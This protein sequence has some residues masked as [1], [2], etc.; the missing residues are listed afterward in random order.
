MTRRKQ[1]DSLSKRFPTISALVGSIGNS[2]SQHPSI[3]GGTAA[4]VVAFGFVSINALMYQ[5]GKHPAPLYNTRAAQ[6]D[7]TSVASKE[8]PLPESRVTT[9]KIEHSDPQSTASIPRKNPLEAINRTVLQLQQG[10]R[11]KGFYTGPIDGVLGP[12]TALSLRTYQQKAGLAP[13]GEP[14]DT[15][16][17]HML[18]S[19]HKSV[20]IPSARPANTVAAIQPE[21][22]PVQQ[23]ASVKESATDPVADLI[24][25]V[26]K[27]LSNI[28]YSEVKVD[29][30]IG[31]Q[32]STAIADF[33]KHYRLP[34]TGQPDSLVLQKLREIGAL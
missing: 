26:Q 4:F 9:F 27:G 21:R 32:T 15:L 8:I 12:Q 6:V 33:Q 5:P 34:I 2:I 20:A 29:G 19:E 1:P 7:E 31:E 13:T 16:L 18:I 22:Q 28:A 14:S 25:S 24:I 3:A 23:V 11:E 30:V 17:V 10:L